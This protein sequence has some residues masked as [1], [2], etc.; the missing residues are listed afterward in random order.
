MKRT[1]LHIII[2]LLSYIL[3]CTT[4]INAQKNN[5]ANIIGFTPSSKTATI[6]GLSF[7]YTLLVL[8][9]KYANVNGIQLNVD[10]ITV[11]M[12]FLTLI[13]A[14][15]IKAGEIDTT[16][17]SDHQNSINGINFT[18]FDANPSTINGI[19]INI[20]GGRGNTTNGFST[21]LVNSHK[22]IHGL[23][24]GILRNAGKKCRGV[25]IGLVNECHNLKGLQIGLW[26]KNS[27][28]ST[29]L[30]NWNF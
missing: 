18:L 8:K 5:T 7:N 9:K 13:H 19:E 16:Y 14:P 3:L 6:N 11:F 23:T 27:K 25:Q 29:P 20:S 22:T 26:N 10:P 15:I 28:R 21:G 1:S 24:L 17:N 2:C 12:P 30:I 4:S